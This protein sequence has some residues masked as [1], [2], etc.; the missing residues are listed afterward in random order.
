MTTNKTLLFAFCL[1]GGSSCSVLPCPVFCATHVLVLDKVDAIITSPPY[2][3]VY[4][5]FKAGRTM[6]LSIR[7]CSLQMP[8]Y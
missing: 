1:W 3:G 7:R 5:Y 4:D 2:P 8:L 6:S